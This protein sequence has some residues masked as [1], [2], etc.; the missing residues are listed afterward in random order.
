MGWRV[1]FLG[2]WG[3]SFVVYFV[4]GLLVWIGIRVLIALLFRFWFGEFWVVWLILAWLLALDKLWV[5]DLMG[6]F[7][8]V[9][10]LLGLVYW[11]GLVYVSWPIGRL[12]G[13]DAWVV[14]SFA[15]FGG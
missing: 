1:W 14:V 9:L 5:C 8:L 3:C 4:V 6:C 11:F 10:V 7:L 2:F 12:V 13:L 15:R